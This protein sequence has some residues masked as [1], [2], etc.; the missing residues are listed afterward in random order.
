MNGIPEDVKHN[1]TAIF[2]YWLWDRRARSEADIK[3]AIAQGML[4][5]RERLTDP[6]LLARAIEATGMVG[7]EAVDEAVAAERERCA[8]TAEQILA[9]TTDRYRSG[10]NAAAVEIAAAIRQPTTS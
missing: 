8:T 9:H 7:K 3:L 1:A 4:A 5:E 6:A 10:M 2:D